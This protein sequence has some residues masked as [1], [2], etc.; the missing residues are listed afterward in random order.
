M[1]KQVKK[2]VGARLTKSF[3]ER[4]ELMAGMEKK[5]PKRAKVRESMLQDT[6]AD[7]KTAEPTEEKFSASLRYEGA[8]LADIQALVSVSTLKSIVAF[9][10][11][12]GRGTYDDHE[13]AV[14]ECVQ[15]YDAGM[16]LSLNTIRKAFRKE[17]ESLWNTL[18]SASGGEK[19]AVQTLNNIVIGLTRGDKPRMTLEDGSYA[20][21]GS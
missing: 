6:L 19:K 8:S 5:D 9:T 18:L 2:P 15:K 7:I 3:A 11:T 13:N 4:K 16:G 10:L 21:I 1:S 14:L 12:T 20:L 17:H